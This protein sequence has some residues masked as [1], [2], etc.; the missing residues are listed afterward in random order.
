MGRRASGI[1]GAR[2][3][4][5][6]GDAPAVGTLGV[7]PQLSFAVDIVRALEPNSVAPIICLEGPSAVGKTSLAA[8]LALAGAAVVPEL[9]GNPPPTTDPSEW[10]VAGH[11][12]NWA[13]AMK[14]AAVAPLVVLDGDP[15]KGLWYN[16]TYADAGSPTLDEVAAA[17]RRVVKSGAL[18]FP[19]VYVVLGA[20][21]EQLRQR[22]GGDLARAR[23]NF[24]LHL[25][26]L[27]PQQ[28]YFAAVAAV[29]PGCVLWLETTDRAAQA[30]AVLAEVGKLPRSG[31]DAPRLLDK[32]VEWLKENAPDAP[33]A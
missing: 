4:S 23:R 5:V 11:A 26:L 21:E 17:Y 20:T 8:D 15:F 28:R 33:A 29:A 24:E 16:W 14:L 18:R 6:D 1:A 13:H 12:A 31:S 2:I 19:D 3:A 25:R 7:R 9:I 22:R 32:L 27:R 10:F 30:A